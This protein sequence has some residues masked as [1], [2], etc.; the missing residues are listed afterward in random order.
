MTAGC[1]PF[2]LRRLLAVA[3]VA[4]SLVLVAGALLFSRSLGNILSLDVGFRQDDVVTA[5][6]MFQRLNLPAERV[7]GFK[8][9]L[10]D[11][12]RAIP[13]VEAAAITHIVPL[14][15][16]GGGTAWI[17]GAGTRQPKHTSLSRVGPGYFKDAGSAVAFGT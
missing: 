1:E 10:V 11:R 13:G 6:A 3:Q 8:D 2:T 4:L 15:D 17:D 12:V 9:E 14:R 16:W 5:T 7:P